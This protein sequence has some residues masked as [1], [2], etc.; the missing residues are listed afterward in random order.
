MCGTAV[1]WVARFLSGEFAGIVAGYM[2]SGLVVHIASGSDRHTEVLSQERVRIG[3]GEGCQVRLRS[4]SL[5]ADSGLVLE[6]A[7]TNGHYRVTEFDPSLG[8]T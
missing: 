2:A 8:I 6:L 3:P 5:P 1:E 7:R 4:S